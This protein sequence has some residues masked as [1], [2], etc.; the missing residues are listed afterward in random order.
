VAREYSRQNFIYPYTRGYQNITEAGL[1][2]GY[3]PRMNGWG[4]GRQVDVQLQTFNGYQFH[5]A[6]AAGLTTSIDTYGPVTLW[7]V[8]LGI[9]GDLT[10]TK[11]RPYYGLDAGYA[12]DWLNNP[13]L[14]TNYDGGF[15]W[16]PTLGLKFNSQKT[17]ALVLNLGYRNQWASSSR[18]DFDRTTTEKL[19]YK[20][21]LFR[22][23]MSF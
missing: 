6:L 12:L 17:H 20:R 22:I 7:P 3:R 18:Q 16:S 21:V 9:R 4:G 1:S 5:P 23:G 19:H 14:G 10:R 2:V 11:I 15:M 8:A 13:N